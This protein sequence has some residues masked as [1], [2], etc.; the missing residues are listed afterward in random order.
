MCSMVTPPALDIGL[1]GGFRLVYQGERVTSVRSARLQSLLACL[2]LN[3]DTPQRRQH[4]AFRFWPDSTEKQARTNL[5]HLLHDLRHALPDGN[6]FIRAD[7]Q[8][9][10]WH[11]DAP[12]TLDV[13]SF[14]EAL[15]RA[16]EAEETG[17]GEAGCEALEEAARLYR[18]DLL[19]S[20]Y[21]EWIEPERLRLREAHLAALER[22]VGLLEE[23]E[24][25]PQAIHYGRQLLQ[26]SPLHEQTYACL[27][28][29]H[30]ANGDRAGALRVYHQCRATLGR[31]LSVAP[32]PEIRALHERVLKLDPAED[33]LAAAVPEAFAIEFS[34]VG[35]E[36]EG[37]RLQAAWQAAETAR[38]G[39]VL[40][41]GEPGI[42]KT[43]LA[44]ELLAWAARQE[45]GCARSRSYEAE[46]RLAYGPIAE[47]LRRPALREG[48]RSLE[49]VWLAEVARILPEVL[50]ERPDL[51]RPGPLT[52]SWRRRHFFEALERAVL[53]A[54]PPLVLLIDDLQW[55]DAGTLEWLDHLLHAAADAPVLIV[56]T[57]RPEEV[58]RDHPLHALLSE[59]RRR[60][61]LTEIP[62]EP[63]DAEETAA[64]AGLITG[65]AL[66]AEQ[67]SH[68][69]RE[70]EGNPLFI[71]ESV[72]ASLI[73]A[74]APAGS[75]E[76]LASAVDDAP[77]PGHRSG[78]PREAAPSPL[79][80]EGRPPS[81]PPR[82]HAVIAQ[83]L[84]RLSPK[85]RELAQLAATI[86]R[87]CTFDVLAEASDLD[88]DD[89]VRGLDEL[90]RRRIL[91]EHDGDAYDFSHDK[92]RE[93]AYGEIPPARRRQVHRHVA[94]ALLAVGSSALDAVA[95]Q[96]A[97]H[98]EFAGAPEEAIL[99]YQRAAEV[100][101]RSYADDEAIRHLTRALTLLQSLPD[102]VT[103]DQRELA[104]L[105]ALSHSL[106][107]AR[108]WAAPEAGRAYER[109]LA[110]SDRS[111]EP[112]Q[113]FAVLWRLHSFYT[114][115]GELGKGRET[116]ERLVQLA[117]QEEDA[118]L[119]ASAEYTQVVS[120]FHLGELE[121][122]WELVGPSTLSLRLRRQ[123]TL[124]GVQA[125]LCLSYASHVLW[126]LGF[127]E[128]ALSRSR[129]ALEL[130]D[131]LSHPFS[132]GIAL[133]YAAML[134][135]FRREPVATRERAE[136]A[137]TVCR[138]YGIPYYLAWGAVLRGWARAEEGEL[139]KGMEE[140]RRALSDLLAT[141]AAL[142]R[143]YYLGLLAGGH[144]AAG[145]VEKGIGV[146]SEALAVARGN[147]ERWCEP[148]LYRLRGELLR[149]GGDNAGAE[150]CFRCAIDRARQL[151]ARAPQLRASTSLGRLW[152]DGGRRDEAHALLEKILDRFTEGFDL[153]DVREAVALLE[154]TGVA[155]GVHPAG[156]RSAKPRS[157]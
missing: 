124:G 121:R 58:A 148:E 56:G 95:S 88:E 15:G 100:A 152:R 147:E 28:R 131:E 85:T 150:G 32:G 91:R 55:C 3:Q 49:P 18:G 47:W 59:L 22:L 40:I 29:L 71:V 79:R 120:L 74:G 66:G 156:R 112:A 41:T 144:A 128:Q 19:P 1:L 30:A 64:L 113:R 103:R 35:R 130:A 118:D 61:Q 23:R 53:A 39:A 12:F 38:P 157:P 116:T 105:M 43:R 126:H 82:V 27:M 34:L 132:Q 77:A 25:Y 81:L 11:A 143:P 136:A 36:G 94:E 119:R 76:D 153:A 13:A 151:R 93:V 45:I 140:M 44:E 46:G 122:V 145:K 142:R 17:D 87:A 14:E 108:G 84:A 96:L 7:A 68:L 133:A 146:L 8:S 16:R 50:A 80:P 127:A 73:E 149:L 97:A 125:V 52:E 51:P 24:A 6:R 123:G 31:E 90:W 92:L 75:P 134:H 72:R 137:M 5:R 69:Y 109:A 26:K 65:G 101:Q 115:R 104:L 33:A 114:V 102:G 9:A 62:L 20:C 70:T 83:R 10:N 139:E 67:T 129:Q 138:K 42:G 78:P 89:L 107:A 110:L 99:H 57:V 2:V 111:S 54:P 141:G 98:Y 60:G 63:L 4:L 154:E 117:D 106:M 86:G 21:D 48:V 155:G 37:E 135:Q